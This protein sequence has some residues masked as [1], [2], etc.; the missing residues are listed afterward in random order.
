MARELRIEVP[1]GWYHEGSRGNYGQRVYH[2][3]LDYA[4]FLDRAAVVARRHGW[5]VIAYV[6]M[7][8]HYH[9]VF[10]VTRGGLSA[11]VQ[12]LHTGHSRMINRR[13]DR[14]KRGHLFQNRFYA[15]LIEKDSHLLEV[16]RYVVLNPRRAGLCDNPD[17]W[18]W[19]SYSACAGT[20]LGHP[21]LATSELLRSFGTSPAEAAD[22]YRRFVRDGFDVPLSDGL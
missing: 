5:I 16:C 2:R 9:F 22:A 1:G 19:S 17:E 20:E 7:P 14:T 18:P 4:I 8:N 21:L 6:L 10:Q 3:P 15:G 12:V 13:L 11:G